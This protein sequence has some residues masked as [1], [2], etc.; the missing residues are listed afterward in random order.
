[1]TVIRASSRLQWVQQLREVISDNGFVVGTV[2][3]AKGAKRSGIVYIRR[4]SFRIY[5]YNVETGKEI[6]ADPS[7]VSEVE[8]IEI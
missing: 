8:I 1:M 3:Y 4:N 2:K 7:K 6:T 5:I